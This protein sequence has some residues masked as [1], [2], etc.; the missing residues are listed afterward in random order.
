MKAHAW[1]SSRCSETSAVMRSRHLPRHVHGLHARGHPAQTVGMDC[2][3][4]GRL[5]AALAD[6]YIRQGLYE[7]A[8][9]VYE[10]GLTTVVTVR[11]FS[12]IF[13]TLTQFEESLL[14]H[15]LQVREDGGGGSASACLHSP[16]DKR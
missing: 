14:Q 16:A 12:L 7:K 6:F 13:D 2:A 15:Q 3:Q 1:L 5:W 11:D 8:R 9:D 10:E 4:V